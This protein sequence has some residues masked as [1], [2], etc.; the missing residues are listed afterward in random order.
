MFCRHSASLLGLWITLLFVSL[1]TRYY[2]PI[3][4]TR[5]VTV[6]WNMWLRGD[7]LVPFLNGEPYSHK[8]P[9]LF[10]IMQLGWAIF[11]VNDW[12]PRLVPSIF[13]IGGV[14]LTIR[15]SRKL[16]PSND[17][18]ARISSVI[19][20]GSLLWTVFST[21]V[22]FDMLIAFFTLLGILGILIAVR[23]D[24]IKG[25]ALT[26]L[27]IGLGLLAKGPTI[28]LQI[29]PVA[30]LAPWWAKDNGIVLHRWYKGI[31]AAVLL[32]AVITLLWAIPAGIRGGAVYQHEIFWGQTTDRM[33]DSFAH[34]RPFWWYLAL[35]PAMLFPWLFWGGVLKGLAQLR[36]SLNDQGVR[37]C[38]SWALPVFLAFSLISGKQ[39]HYLLPIFPA[40]SLLVAHGLT[41]L[42]A[43]PG[44]LSR[45]GIGLV[46][47][48]IGIVL[49]VLPHLHRYISIAEWLKYVPAVTGYF[50]LICSGVFLLWKP[51]TIE[52]QVWLIATA[53]LV[54]VFVLHFA[55]IRT[56]GIAYDI[57]PISAKIKAL[58]DVGIPLA[59]DGKYHGQYQFAGRLQHPI[60]QIRDDNYAQWFDAHPSGLVIIY[61]SSDEK[62]P[63]GRPEFIQ[64]Y[65]GGSIG[66]Y[67]RQALLPAQ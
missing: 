17:A 56:G 10:W 40:F 67:S 43:P 46:L 32:G 47:L 19:L 16:W 63:Q 18:I 66:L 22:M 23:G 2:L 61:L 33:V 59:N 21:A 38:L 15:V 9:L 29:L 26:G 20:F 37:F 39:A 27:A 58:Q 41:A 1:C 57:R 8:P 50:L 12:W 51:M 54:M 52:R 31:I 4:E 65:R 30:V 42:K 60:D 13:A 48:A 64:P 53:S 62:A 55:I 6:A 25:W 36:F 11:G 35:M 49:L 3:D 44:R 5:Y 45:I 14:F 34:K 24:D 7:F 28:L